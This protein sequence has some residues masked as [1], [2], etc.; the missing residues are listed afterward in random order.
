MPPAKFKNTPGLDIEFTEPRQVLLPGETLS[1]KVILNTVEDSVSIGSVTA[2]VYGRTK[3]KVFQSYGQSSAVYKSRARLFEV[4][5]ELFKSDYTYQAGQYSWPFNIQLP[6]VPDE[7]CLTG[8]KKDRFKRDVNYLSTDDIDVIEHEMPPPMFHYHGML[9]R[10]CWAYVEYVLEVTVTDTANSHRIRGPQSSSSTRP[11][12]FQPGRREE[13]VRDFGLQSKSDQLTVKSSRLTA[14]DSTLSPTTSKDQNEGLA[15]ATS[16]DPLTRKESRGTSPIRNVFSRLSIS[17]S[18][19]RLALNCTVTYP[20]TFQV[21]HP[22]PIP[23]QLSITPDLN[24]QLTTIDPATF[25]TIRIKSLDL[26]LTCTTRARALTGLW[27]ERDAKTV[28]IYLAKD[29]PL[30]HTFN[31]AP[32][33]TLAEKSKS[34]APPAFENGLPSNVHT[35]NLTSL[36]NP[37]PRILGAKTHRRLHEPLLVPTFKTYNIA[38]DF[39]LKWTIELE[40]ITSKKVFSEKLKGE[41]PRGGITVRGVPDA[42][43]YEAYAAARMA[44][45]GIGTMDGGDDDVDWENLERDG[46]EDEDEDDENQDSRQ[47]GVATA[48]NV[49]VATEKK[50]LRSLFRRS[51]DGG[52]GVGGGTSKN[53][54]KEEYAREERMKREAEERERGGGGGGGEELPRYEA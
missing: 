5:Q 31:L 10:A 21:Y 47:Q 16:N 14:D 3:V 35:V 1:G 8:K 4:T 30:N 25:P 24:P 18:S 11:L 52:V 51:H 28:S 9:G 6:F 45:N 49:G 2:T 22:D 53:K 46:G 44:G 41:V 19:P 50:G 37:T 32:S 15:P 54:E 12:N 40:I 48:G 42:L 27:Q 39:G 26:R 13:I 17:S 29:V 34:G 7:T 20:R 33:T 43:R 36:I 23:F 38:R